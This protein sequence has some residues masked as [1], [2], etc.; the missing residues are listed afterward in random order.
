MRAGLAQIL[1]TLRRTVRGLR[2]QAGLSGICRRGTRP[3]RPA[4]PRIPL[5]A[6]AAGAAPGAPWPGS[7]IREIR[8]VRTISQIRT[9]LIDLHTHT[10]ESDGRCTAAELVAKAAEAGVT[11]LAVTDHDTV[12][13]CE[14]V[15]ARC[16]SSGLTFVTGIEITAMRDDHDVHVLGY[17]IDVTSASLHA[18]LS[19]QRRWR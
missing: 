12:A 8:K 2:G 19:E 3:S 13:G 9:P 7:K 5:A 6:S 4:H 10:T 1:Q 11:V 18:F 14:A 16:A 17:F 15:A